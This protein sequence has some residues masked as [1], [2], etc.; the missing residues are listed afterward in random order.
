MRLTVDRIEGNIVVSYTDSNE[1]REIPVEQFDREPHDGDLYILN[2]NG[3][4]VFLED[5][6][7]LRR[8]EMRSRF[9]RFK[10]K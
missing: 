2:D 7:L 3:T 10:K 5:E 9:D 1:K 4:L 8:N 6:T